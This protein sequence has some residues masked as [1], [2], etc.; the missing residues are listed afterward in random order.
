[1]KI[2]ESALKKLIQKEIREYLEE[3]SS[4]AAGS[5]EGGIVPAKRA[6]SPPDPLR[7]GDDDEESEDTIQPIIKRGKNNG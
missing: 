6:K 7:G 1:M 5:I 4:M 3:M 2:T